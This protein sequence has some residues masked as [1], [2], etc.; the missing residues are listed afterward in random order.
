ME[1]STSVSTVA[2]LGILIVFLVFCAVAIILQV[3]LSRRESKWPGMILPIICICISVV[4]IL[5]LVAFS[6]NTA[7][8][9]AT[10]NGVV[11][12]QTVTQIADTSAVAWTAVITFLL[13]NI[14]TAILLVIY[15][16]SRGKKSRQ[17]AVE[18]MSVQDLG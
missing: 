13:F 6:V 4:A 5:G 8:Y 3:F 11:T 14:P 10:E 1:N 9:T 12:E 2:F 18:K 15:K 16:V 17:R 7:A